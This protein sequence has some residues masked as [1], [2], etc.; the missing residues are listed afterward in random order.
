[1]NRGTKEIILSSF[2][3]VHVFEGVGERTGVCLDRKGVRGRRAVC[4]SVGELAAKSRRL[5]DGYYYLASAAWPTG[6]TSVSLALNWVSMGG[7][8]PAPEGD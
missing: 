4:R 5:G 6:S 3:E 8:G 2:D 1:V 7:P